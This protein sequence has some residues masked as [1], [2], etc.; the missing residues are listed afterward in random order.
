[1]GH[2][3]TCFALV[4]SSIYLFTQSCVSVFVLHL[5]FHVFA[6]YEVDLHGYMPTLAYMKFIYIHGE[7]IVNYV[8]T[9]H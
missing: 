7:C 5:H 2:K 3:G 6:W 4:F 9:Q 8:N 1:M